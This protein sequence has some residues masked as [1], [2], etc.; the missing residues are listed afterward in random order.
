MILGISVQDDPAD[1]VLEQAILHRIVGFR[2]PHNERNAA[3][4]R[5]TF[6]VILNFQ[7]S[8][9]SLNSAIRANTESQNYVIRGV[10]DIT[11]N[12][13]PTYGPE[14]VFSKLVGYVG[15]LRSVEVRE[16]EI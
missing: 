1:G 4:P 8:Q 12:S 16:V 5:S 6:S 14:F 13:P 10:P 15:R 11:N 9:E 2:P 3:E 7:N